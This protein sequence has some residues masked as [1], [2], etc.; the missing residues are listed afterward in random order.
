MEHEHEAGGELPWTGER[1]VTGVSGD[2]A[3]EHLHRYIL[4]MGLASGKAVLDIA[5]GEGYG[6]NLLAGVGRSVI[7]IDINPD[8][9]RHASRKYVRDNLEFRVGS[10]TR[11]PVDSGSIDLVVSFETL[12]HLAEHED[13]MVEIKR[14]LMPGGTLIMSTPDRR[15]YSDIPGYKNPYHV[16]ELYRDEFAGLIDRHFATSLIF[17]QRVCEGSLLVPLATEDVANHKFCSYQG[18]FE[19]AHQEPGLRDPIYLVAVASDAQ[20]HWPSSPSLFEGD[21]LPS[22]KDHQVAERDRLLGQ[23]ASEID[24]LNQGIASRAVELR[25]RTEQLAEQL[26][27]KAQ[28]ESMLNQARQALADQEQ[29]LASE[30]EQRLRAETDMAGLMRS[31]SWRITAPLRHSGRLARAARQVARDRL[32]PWDRGPKLPQPQAAPRHHLGPHDA[33]SGKAGAEQPP[34]PGQGSR[35]G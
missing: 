17:G 22:N 15:N 30:Q 1:L 5:C 14:V 28:V 27:A 21:A 6:S 23:F 18:N 33:H 29:R 34:Q 4:A 25:L 3:L 19:R 20:V 9:I 10:A 32:S 31:R 11:I 12:E 24:L 16:K 26:A 2:V 35:I 8:S 7:G 13:M